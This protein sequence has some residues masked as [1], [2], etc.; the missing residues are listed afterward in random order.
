M[1]RVIK[2]WERICVYLQ[3]SWIYGHLK[4]SLHKSRFS[5][6]TSCCQKKQKRAKQTNS[7]GLGV[8][9]TKTKLF[10]CFALFVFLATNLFWKK[11]HFFFTNSKY[12]YFLKINYTTMKFIEN[13]LS[14]T[15][16]RS[17]NRIVTKT[18][19]CCFMM[20]LEN[21]LIFC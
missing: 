12:P 8:N 21:F 6:K 18:N 14:D 3:N 4:L 1:L 7:L 5:F 20:I 15:N 13:I 10:T 11:K 9:P 17:V 2:Y 19:I 16:S